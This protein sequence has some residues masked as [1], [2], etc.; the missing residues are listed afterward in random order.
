MKIF[1]TIRQSL[2]PG[3]FNRALHEAV[4]N[5]EGPIAMRIQRNGS[6]GGQLEATFE[7]EEAGT[8]FARFMKARQ[9][10]HVVTNQEGVRV[11]LRAR[12]GY[13]VG[14]LNQIERHMST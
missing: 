12:T 10:W 9:G 7:T 6:L 11:H 4:Q 2:F 5:N 1:E 8:R 3:R 14:M 13:G